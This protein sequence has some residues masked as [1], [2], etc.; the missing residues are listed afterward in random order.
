MICPTPLTFC[1][2]P[3]D[4]HCFGEASG[5]EVFERINNRESNLAGA[6]LSS[7][8]PREDADA[9]IRKLDQPDV[10]HAI[11]S[12]RKTL[13]V[14]KLR[15]SVEYRAI[16]GSRRLFIPFVSFW[17]P[18]YFNAADDDIFPN[19]RDGGILHVKHRRVRNFFKAPVC[20]LV[21]KKD[22]CGSLVSS[23]FD[24]RS[25]DKPPID[26]RGSAIVRIFPAR[27]GKIQQRRVART[28]ATSEILKKR[29]GRFYTRYRVF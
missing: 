15:A 11:R 12:L 6:G 24:P 23:R 2:L 16:A 1:K 14:S 22:F 13:Q 28:L 5:S 3:G 10:F 19:K 4:G 27:S 7:L 21:V 17:P 9:P 18:F 29:A 8:R 20:A 25:N 26:H